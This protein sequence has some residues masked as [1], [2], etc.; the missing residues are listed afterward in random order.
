MT[1]AIAQDSEFVHEH[2]WNWSVWI[3]GPAGELDRIEAVEYALHPTF[4]E[5]VRRI[6]DP[7]TKFRLDERCSGEFEI[8]VRVFRDDGTEE[9]L[10]HWLR[11]PGSTGLPATRKEA[12]AF[13]A[14]GAADAAWAHAIR[15][16][17]A[18]NG[19]RAMDV[20][21][22]LDPG[23]PWQASISD[24][25]E[26]ADFV[27]GVFSD[28]TSPSVLREV[29]Q[30]LTSNIPVVPIVI[31]ADVDVPESIAR[32]QALSLDEQADVTSAIGSLFDSASEGTS[33]SNWPPNAIE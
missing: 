27:I 19:V 9:H 4:D 18:E 23:A 26:A 22:L 30:A 10:K 16:A 28:E 1:L 3:E 21:D 17:L 8:N 7:V 25:I 20:D 11:L 15:S 33:L 2:M 6:A 29:T 13:V 12:T 32:I 24:A 14:Y 31:G 5:P